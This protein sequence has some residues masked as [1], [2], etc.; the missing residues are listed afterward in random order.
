MRRFA[1]IAI[2]LLV[3]ALA[4][5]ASVAQTGRA[6][7]CGNDGMHQVGYTTNGNTDPLGQNASTD[8]TAY[9]DYCGNEQERYSVWSRT[10]SSLSNVSI[11]TRTW[12]CSFNFEVLHI[13]S[14]VRWTGWYSG[15]G[16]G[17]RADD[18]GLEGTTACTSAACYNSNNGG[19][20]YDTIW[21]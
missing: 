1:R 9:Q 15:G 4:P 21:Q 7:A 14:S 18:V 13:W 12:Q 10:G 2:V 11:T 6:F 3:L 19:V 20:F 5:A 17:N 8:I 16:C